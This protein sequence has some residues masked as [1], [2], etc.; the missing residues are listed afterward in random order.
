MSTMATY[1]SS[2]TIVYSTFCLGTD[3]RKHSASLA[4]VRGIQRWPVNSPCKGPVTRKMFPFDDA[5][6]EQEPVMIQFTKASVYCQASI[7]I[8]FIKW[9]QIIMESGKGLTPIKVWQIIWTNDDASMSHLGRI[10]LLST[11]HTTFIKR[12]KSNT[13]KN[14]SNHMISYSYSLF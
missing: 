3:Q 14:I 5:I 1:I 4:F 8:Y 6:M 10:C 9:Q 2:L 13:F 7:K 11:P 12:I